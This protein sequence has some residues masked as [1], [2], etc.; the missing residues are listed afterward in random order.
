MAIPREKDRQEMYAVCLRCPLG[1]LNDGM[2]VTLP[3]PPQ[4]ATAHSLIAD[5]QDARNISSVRQGT[6]MVAFKLPTE[7]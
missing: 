6:A 1:G 2:A 5:R 3:H 4:H 7:I